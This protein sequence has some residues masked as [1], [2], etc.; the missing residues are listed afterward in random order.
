MS[1]SKGDSGISFTIDGRAFE[2][3]DPNQTAGSL[4]QLAGL[5]ANGY[6]LGQLHGNDPKPKLYEDHD[7]IH[8]H[9]G[10]R[11]VSIRERAAVA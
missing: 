7:R 1:D 10:D 6:D 4:L 3:T 9:P 8:V 2:L 11:F 5:D